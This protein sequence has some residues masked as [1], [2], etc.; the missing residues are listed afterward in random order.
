MGTRILLM[1][2]TQMADQVLS[3]SFDRSVASE[4]LTLP[5]STG[6]ALSQPLAASP[7]D[8]VSARQKLKNLKSGKALWND[9]AQVDSP[10]KK[11]GRQ[12]SGFF[13]SR[14]SRKLE[15]TELG[16]G[17]KKSSIRRGEYPNMTPDGLTS[18]SPSI[19]KEA[20]VAGQST[21]DTTT[22]LDVGFGEF[23][24]VR[25]CQLGDVEPTNLPSPRVVQ[26]MVPED[27]S[28]SEEGYSRPLNRASLEGEAMTNIEEDGGPAR[29][30]RSAKLKLNSKY[31]DFR[32]VILIIERTLQL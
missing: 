21:D 4:G 5:M 7:K 18:V 2:S 10:G 16:S 22:V 15:T 14:S 9:P 24:A 25:V 13:S 23:G 29:K 31:N 12:S 11:V 17:R 30:L 26:T 20:G 8:R 6:D 1:L 27:V 28:N 32:C 19:A 3:Q